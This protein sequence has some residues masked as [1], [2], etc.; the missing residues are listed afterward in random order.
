MEKI[1]S[2]IR[3]DILLHIIVKK[4]DFTTGR[5]DIIEPH[6]FLQ[7][8]MLNLDKGKTFSPHEHIWKN[9][10]EKII[11]QES[12]CCIQ[13]SVKCILYDLDGT[14]VAERIIEAGD[15]SFTLQGGHNYE[16]L[17]DNSLI[18]EYKTGPYLGQ[19]LDK[20]FI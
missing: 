4:K 6:N 16:V 15:A 11:A 7:C 2:R 10:P 19:E 14:I 12:W 18:W 3:Q 1:Y 5:Q 9:G 13:G 8:S 17:E 20:V